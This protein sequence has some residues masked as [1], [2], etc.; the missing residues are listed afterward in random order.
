M[1]VGRPSLAANDP[2]TF[3]FFKT[4][5]TVHALGIVNQNFA[6]GLRPKANDQ[7]QISGAAGDGERSQEVEDHLVSFEPL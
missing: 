4:R 3:E 2:S 5:F 6:G 1:V 7:R